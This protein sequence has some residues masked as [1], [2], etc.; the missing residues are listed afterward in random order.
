MR[1]EHFD[2][3]ECIQAALS[4]DDNMADCSLR[5]MMHHSMLDGELGDAV[6]IGASS[7][8]HFRSNLASVGG[9]AL[10]PRVVAAFQDGW[11]TCESICPNFQRGV[12]GS[13][14]DK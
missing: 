11:T 12:S 6:I 13:A 8:G 3:L 2:A 5:W 7:L 1:D 9:G 4:P 14:L 10:D